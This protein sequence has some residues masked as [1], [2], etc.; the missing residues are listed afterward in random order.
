MHDNRDIIAFEIFQKL[1]VTEI[2]HHKL[3]DKKIIAENAKWSYWYAIDV[4][5]YQRFILGE[6]A[7]KTNTIYW[8][9]YQAV[10]L[11]KYPPLN[12]LYL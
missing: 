8:K 4:L 1:S 7:I 11:N 2:E 9:S 3:E 5:G 10:V 6:E 12:I